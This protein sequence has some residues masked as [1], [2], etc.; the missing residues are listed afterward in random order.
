V[1]IGSFRYQ[2]HLYSLSTLLAGAR[3]NSINAET[4]HVDFHFSDYATYLTLEREHIA[5]GVQHER[6]QKALLEPLG[7]TISVRHQS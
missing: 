1:L 4:V 2:A 6:L 7:S 3:Q 5:W